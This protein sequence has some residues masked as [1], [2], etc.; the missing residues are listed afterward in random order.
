M[1]ELTHS[2]FALSLCATV[3]VLGISCTLPTSEPTTNN[4][5]PTTDTTPPTVTAPTTTGSVDLKPGT[6]S[7]ASTSVQQ[8]GSVSLTIPVQNLDTGTVTGTISVSLYL[9]SS[10]TFNTGTDTK[11]G[12]ASFDNIGSSAT[13]NLNTST[14]VTAP[15]AN[16]VYYLYAVV[17]PAGDVV[18]TNTANNTSTVADALRLLVYATPSPQSY[19]V[20]VETYAPAGGG[21][22]TTAIALYRKT[23]TGVVQF[24]SKQTGGYPGDTAK[25]DFTGSG[26]ELQS[27]TY[28]VLVWIPNTY[29]FYSGAYALEVRSANVGQVSFNALSSEP[30]ASNNATGVTEGTVDTYAVEPSNAYSVPVGQAANWYIPTGGFDWFTFTLP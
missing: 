19:P 26:S 5:T 1:R 12:S 30:T 21:T 28:Y 15:T 18:D 6:A 22:A 7:S 16:L 25:L 24:V 14:A 29:S 27:G 17:D 20:Y 23:S 9:A 10:S 2:G 3:F 4:T 8:G 11:L 13:V